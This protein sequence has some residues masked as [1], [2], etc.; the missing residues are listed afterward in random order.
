MEYNFVNEIKGRALL[1]SSNPN[2]GRLFVDYDASYCMTSSFDTFSQF[3]LYQSLN[4]LR[5]NNTHV[6][7]YGKGSIDM[8]EG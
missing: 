2:N 6:K 3:E 4:I 5:V 1:A 7:T 8:G